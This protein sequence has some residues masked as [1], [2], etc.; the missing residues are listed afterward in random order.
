MRVYLQFKYL[1]S[2]N[3]NRKEFEIFTVESCY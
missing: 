2:I 1:L 3:V